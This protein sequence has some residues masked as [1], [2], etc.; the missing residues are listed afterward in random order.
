MSKLNILG[1]ILV[2]VV[3]CVIA[4]PYAVKNVFANEPGQG[5]AGFIHASLDSLPDFAVNRILN[6]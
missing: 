6:M 2:T 3:S 1:V 4:R 5:S